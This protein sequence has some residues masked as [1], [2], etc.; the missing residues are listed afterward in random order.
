MQN[1]AMWIA[2][3]LIQTQMAAGQNFDSILVV[4]EDVLVAVIMTASTNP[5]SNMAG[6][7]PKAILSELVKRVA[8]KLSQ[9]PPLDIEKILDAAARAKEQEERTMAMADRAFKDRVRGD[10]E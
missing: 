10:E 2:G 6:N 1:Q 8:G 3:N 4:L 9:F 7:D 5:H